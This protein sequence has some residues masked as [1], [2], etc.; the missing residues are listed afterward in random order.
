M[1]EQK[2]KFIADRML[3]KL[4]TYLRMLGFDTL[5]DT[6]HDPCPLAERAAKEERIILTRDTAL[7]R[8]LT[9]SASVFIADN[10]PSDQLLAVVR[11]LRITSIDVHP[12]SLCLKCN[13]KLLKKEREFV[14]SAVPDYVLA[15]HQDFSVCPQC[16]RVYWQ[17]SHKKRM[18]KMVARL[19]P[20]EGKDRRAD[21]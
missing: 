13:R 9:P 11:T 10:L 12:F 14:A 1:G 3:G 21:T 17:G 4:A 19:F 5:Y 18:E 2:L 20:S 8:A 7:R 6:G 15:T 16:G